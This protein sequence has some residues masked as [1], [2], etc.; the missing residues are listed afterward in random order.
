MQNILNKV[1]KVLSHDKGMCRKH[2]GY[3]TALFD[4]REFLQS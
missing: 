4:V 1:F 3:N 2:L